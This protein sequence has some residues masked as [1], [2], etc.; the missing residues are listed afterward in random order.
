MSAPRFLWLFGE[1]GHVQISV[2]VTDG[3]AL[4][5]AEESELQRIQRLFPEADIGPTWNNSPEPTE[6]EPENDRFEYDGFKLAELANKSDCG[7]VRGRHR[8]PRP[9]VEL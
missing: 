2:W 5:A 6:P 9:S 4:T 7:L 3:E 1:R 8:R